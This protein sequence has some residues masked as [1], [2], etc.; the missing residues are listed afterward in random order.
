[1]YTTALLIASNKL[2]YGTI[3]LLSIE[4]F[5]TLYLSKISQDY[6]LFL[7]NSFTVI[8]ASPIDFVTSDSLLFEGGNF[9]GL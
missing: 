1:M 5:V 9:L 7:V 8:Y 2:S 3:F 6:Y 4:W